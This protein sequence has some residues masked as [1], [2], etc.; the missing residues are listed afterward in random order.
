[1]DKRT[2]GY[3]RDGILL[4][5]KKDQILIY[6]PAW[7]NLKGAVISERLQSQGVSYCIILFR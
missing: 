3:P 4:G 1:M 7:V 6:P 2:V 5:K